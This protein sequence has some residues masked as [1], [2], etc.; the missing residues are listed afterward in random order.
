MDLISEK[1]FDEIENKLYLKV[2]FT[3]YSKKKVEF[4]KNP[5]KPNGVYFQ[6]NNGCILFCLINLGYLDE[7]EIPDSMKNYKNHPYTEDEKTY[8]DY[9]KRVLSI[10]DLGQLWI[11]LGGISPYKEKGTSKVIELDEIKKE[12]YEILK[13]SIENE[14][15]ESVKKALSIVKN[16]ERFATVIGN[17]PIKPILLS[18]IM[19]EGNL[20]LKNAID[21]GIIKENTPI[22]CINH[23]IAFNEIIEENS[24]KYYIFTDSLPQFYSKIKSEMKDNSEFDE[25]NG[26]IKSNEN[27]ALINII[28]DSDKKIGILKL[29]YLD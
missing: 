11:N 5:K 24:N 9:L 22:F 28:E 17:I 18:E 7:N 2:G 15:F 29:N 14:N 26:K 13:D 21:S 3:K 23:Y 10:I 20:N 25:K 16:H 4:L 8:K 1:E 27:A 19:K 12:V 6:Y